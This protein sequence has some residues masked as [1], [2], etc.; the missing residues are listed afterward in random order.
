MAPQSTSTRR[1]ALRTAQWMVE[2][3][4]DPFRARIALANAY[5]KLERPLDAERT[6]REALEIAPDDLRIYGALAAGGDAD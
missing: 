1:E 4:G 2:H 5:E 3:D 6:L